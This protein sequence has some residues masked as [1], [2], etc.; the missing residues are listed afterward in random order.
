MAQKL[1]IMLM[2]IKKKNLFS[3][4]LKTFVKQ[5][6]K[7]KTEKKLKLSTALIKKVGKI[8]PLIILLDFIKK[9]R[10]FSIIIFLKINGSFQ[11]IPIEIKQNR[12]KCLILRWL[13]MN[14]NKRSEN[15]IVEAL[16]K[17][18]LETTNYHSRT[19]KFCNDTHKIAEANKTFTK[20]F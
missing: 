19:I 6:K 7:E 13:I 16:S 2:L 10:P 11:K 20:F 8:N 15:S 9:V 3:K 1:I 18:L 4:F 5:G 12:Q 14:S 17:E